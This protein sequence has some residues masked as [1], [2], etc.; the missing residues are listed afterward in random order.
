MVTMIANQNSED[1]MLFNGTEKIFNPELYQTR[2]KNYG[3]WGC[4]IRYVRGTAGESQQ[5]PY[6]QFIHQQLVKFVGLV[7]LNA[8]SADRPFSAT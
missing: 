5:P 2:W 7:V 8:V 3:R 1:D 6:R 4:Y